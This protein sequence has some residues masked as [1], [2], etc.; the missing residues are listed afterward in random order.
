MNG[1]V[2]RLLP[3]YPLRTLGVW[4]LVATVQ[5]M[6][7][8]ALWAMGTG[9]APLIG[10]VMGALVFFATHSSPA[11]VVRT[12]PVTSRDIALARWWMSIGLPALFVTA[13]LF[14]AWAAN[15]GWGF[16]APPISGV[17]LAALENLGVL[18]ML[19]AL[20]LPM[21]N[22]QRSNVGVFVGFWAPLT[23]VALYGLSP[24]L[25]TVPASIVLALEGLALAVISYVQARQGR[26]TCIPAPPIRRLI[27]TRSARESSER[28]HALK[29]WSVLITQLMR[30]TALLAL[31]CV[32]AIAA[33]RVLFPV[34]DTVLP[35]IFVSIAGIAGA[36]LAR[37]WV[38]AVGAMQCLPI[39]RHALALIVCVVLMVPGI[40][41]CLLAAA[42]H[43]VNP[44]W[45]VPIPLIFIPVFTI[46]PALTVPWKT[47][48]SSHVI[49]S[50]AQRWA[51]M[52]QLA[53]WP[54]WAAPFLSL[55]FTKL[56]LPWFNF[57]AVA[58]LLVFAATGY[59]AVLLHIRSGTGFERMPDPLTTG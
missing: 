29:G 39:G 37:R 6:Q 23:A 53:I 25:L 2:F 59:F 50:T 40:F 44:A 10:G 26:V 12:L 36:L 45:G 56:P 18:G 1:A 58:I 11:S 43:Q 4:V 54:L 31:A 20:P 24:E 16:P 35:Q 42:A 30:S 13:C 3:R 51:P 22:A 46:I 8:S 49:A 41:T 55:A 48:E 38:F 21:L 34:L 9:R 32:A 7:A 52:F 28:H 5:P 57:V 19:A 17:L 14:A 15:L 33:L 47:P 27:R